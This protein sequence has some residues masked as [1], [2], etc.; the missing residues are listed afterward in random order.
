MTTEYKKVEITYDES[1]N[2]WCFTLRGKDRSASSL[3]NAKETI[4]KPAPKDSVPFTKIEAWHF[5]Y[6]NTPRWAVVTGLG[7]K[8]WGSGTY[9]WLTKDKKRS[10]ERVEGSV[11]P[12]NSTNDAICAQIIEKEKQRETLSTEIHKL[13]SKLLPLV[14]P[15]NEE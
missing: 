2:L 9:V 5:E 15:K 7:E 10:K 11:F 6:G 1:R 14:L 8:N 13:K 4:D 12:Q 3:A